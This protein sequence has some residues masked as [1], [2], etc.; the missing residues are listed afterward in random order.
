MR[1]RVTIQGTAA[2]LPENKRALLRRAAKL[3]L[4]RMKADPRSEVNLVLTDDAGI[5][6][7]NLAY[8][9]MDDPT[10][11][12]SFPCLGG[13]G[14]TAPFEHTRRLLGDIVVSTE[15][16][17]EQAGLYG[18]SMEREMAFLVVHGM[19]HLLGL[20]HEAKEERIRMEALQRQILALTGLARNP[21]EKD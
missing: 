5:R 12:L 13:R 10:D 6:K 15:R 20:D 16:A 14:I 21:G 8:R 3:C 19:L 11:V 2:P 18:H 7:L 17:A 9:D 4:I 1:L